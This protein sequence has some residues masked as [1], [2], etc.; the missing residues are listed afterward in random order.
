MSLSSTSPHQAVLDHLLPVLAAG[1]FEQVRGRSGMTT[2]ERAFPNGAHR[3]SW[4]IDFE[5]TDPTLAIFL[6]T[7]QDEV[8]DA[9]E[10]CQPGLRAWFDGNLLD[11]PI[12]GLVLEG[13]IEFA[14]LI[15]SDL[16]STGIALS[17]VAATRARRL[18]GLG[19]AL[20][21]LAW[22]RL[23]SAE[24]VPALWDLILAETERR[25]GVHPDVRV[26]ILVGLWMRDDRAEVVAKWWRKDLVQDIEDARAVQH[27]TLTGAGNAAARERK[28]AAFDSFVAAARVLMSGR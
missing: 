24:T 19:L 12:H 18:E 22:P 14:R 28:L 21:E 7:R 15:Y 13:G 4:R 20:K 17:N 5:E 10:R 9:L 8:L 25:F 6:H 16:E 27:S 26:S 11:W 3:L 1:G 2:F 23:V